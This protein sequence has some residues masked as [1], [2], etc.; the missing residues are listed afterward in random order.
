VHGRLTIS[1]ITVFERMRGYRDAIRR[2]L[3]FEPHMRQFE[4]LV[5]ASVV[6]SVDGKVA[7]VAAR[8]WAHSTGKVRRRI[9]DLLIAATA[10]ANGLPLVTRNRRDFRP[11]TT[12]PAVSLRLLEW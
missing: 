2:G 7:D 6:L 12:V 5:A 1:A 11:M 8:L 3:P 4:M 10:S 9:G